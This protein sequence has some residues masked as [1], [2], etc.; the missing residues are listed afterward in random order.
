MTLDEVLD[1]VKRIGG[2]CRLV[3]VT[4]GEPLLQPMTGELLTRLCDANYTVLLET[5]GACDISA[6]DR[7]VHRI[8]DIKTPGSGETERNHWPNIEQLRHHDEVKFIL[9]DRAD[10]DWSRQV[11]IEHGLA[12]RVQAVLLS[13]A[14][15]VAGNQDIAGSAG[16]TLRRLAEWML[17][18]DLPPGVRLQTQLHKLIWEPDTRGV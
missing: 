9:T 7:R 18:D 17:A 8:M 11:I 6:V 10:Y 4:G 13:A 16:L 14:A 2:R 5:N 1:Q 3:E 15:P 12:E